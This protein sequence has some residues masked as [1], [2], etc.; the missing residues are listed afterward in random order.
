MLDTY[1][2]REF[3]YMFNSR[4]SNNEDEE[5]EVEP[6]EGVDDVE[7]DDYSEGDED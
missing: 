7:E 5:E 2:D 6:E 1:T 3:D 4:N